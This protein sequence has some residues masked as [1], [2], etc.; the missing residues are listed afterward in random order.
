MRHS[1]IGPVMTGDVVRV[2]FGTPFKE[3][4]R[5]LARHRISGLPVVDDDER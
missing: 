1:E 5:L 3:M 2:E 4:A